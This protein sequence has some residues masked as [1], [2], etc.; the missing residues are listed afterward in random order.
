MSGH[1][2]VQPNIITNAAQFT[3]DR[4]VVPLITL[5]QAISRVSR[6]LGY[7]CLYCIHFE[8]SVCVLGMIA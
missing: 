4:L 3:D 2:D 5:D 8:Q 7:I 1:A 6:Q